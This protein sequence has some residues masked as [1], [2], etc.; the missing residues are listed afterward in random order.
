AARGGRCDGEHRSR[1][2]RRG[3]GWGEWGGAGVC[4]A[5]SSLPSGLAMTAAVPAYTFSDVPFQERIRP[6]SETTV[7]PT[8]RPTSEKKIISN[9]LNSK[10][11][12]GPRTIDGINISKYNNL[13]H[14]RCA[15]TLVVLADECPETVAREAQEMA[16]ALDP[17]GPVE[18][19]IALA[20]AG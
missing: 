17:V 3:E 16:Q 9:R 2:T 4:A 12:T 5:D 11:S 13:T 1:W 19:G 20:Y 15:R 7:E 6:M 14:G 8:K 18:E 10:K